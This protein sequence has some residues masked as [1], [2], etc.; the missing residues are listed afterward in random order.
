MGLQGKQLAAF[1]ALLVAATLLLL[2]AAVLIGSGGLDAELIATLR[3]PRVLAAAG[4]GALLALSGLAMQ[5][6]GRASCRERV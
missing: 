2:G 5:E 4:V 6:I 3:A 1:A